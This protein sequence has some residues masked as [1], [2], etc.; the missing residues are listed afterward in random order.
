[1]TAGRL[2]I[3]LGIVCGCRSADTAAP[4]LKTTWADGT[5][6]VVRMNNQPMPYR[7][8]GDTPYTITDSLT[9]TVIGWATPISVSVFP[10]VRLFSVSTLPPTT[11][12]CA[13]PFGYGTLTDSTL[14]TRPSGVSTMIGNCNA[15]WVTLSLR[16]RGDTLTGLWVRDT[17]QLVRRP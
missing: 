15:N 8:R 16:R 12:S 13:E 10:Y 11:L 1:M 9:L 7:D 2:V 17:V 4:G 5:W 3:L 14:T 6:V